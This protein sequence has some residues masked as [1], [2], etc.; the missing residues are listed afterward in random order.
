VIY[1]ETE[2]AER[3]QLNHICGMRYWKSIEFLINKM[4]AFIDAM[5]HYIGY[6][7]AYEQALEITDKN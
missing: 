2:R 7:Y 1:H 6:E 4:K 5:V 3:S